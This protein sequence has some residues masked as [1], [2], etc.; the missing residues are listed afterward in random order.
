MAQQTLIT[1]PALAFKTDVIYSAQ[2]ATDY[3][4]FIDNDSYNVVAG[5]WLN[6]VKPENSNS[7]MYY[8][9]YIAPA[10]FPG[11]ATF[12]LYNTYGGVLVAN[13]TVN[14]PQSGYGEATLTAQNESGLTGNVKLV[15]GISSSDINSANRVFCCPI[16]CLVTNPQATPNIETVC[17][18]A[19]P[20][21]DVFSPSKDLLVRVYWKPQNG[22]ISATVKFSIQALG[23]TSAG[24][25]TRKPVISGDCVGVGDPYRWNISDVTVPAFGNIRPLDMMYLSV[26]HHTS[27]PYLGKLLIPYIA[28]AQDL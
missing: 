27:S 17:Y 6:G 24:V 25:I 22:T 4:C 7:Y 12:E 5:L 16:P 20:L 18:T 19:V 10:S 26:Q 11:N 13:A 28:L 1:L 15:G 21:P 3:L 9:K 8:W 14:V 23:Y 2:R